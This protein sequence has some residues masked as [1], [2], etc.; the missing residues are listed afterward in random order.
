MM[1]DTIE[2]EVN[3]MESGNIK[4]NLD[5]IVKK[6]QGEA[7]PSK[8]QSLNEKFDLIMKTMERLMERMS[9]ENKPITKDQNDFYPRNQ[10]FRRVLVPQIRKRDQRDQG[11]QHIKPPFQN[12]YANKYFD[13][14]IQDQMQMCS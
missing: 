1:R 10:N 4:H 6:V 11:D 14:I 2:V 9:V 12:N 3:L 8:S 5:R 13:Q 7:H